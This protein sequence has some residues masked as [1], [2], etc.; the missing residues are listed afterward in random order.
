MEKNKNLHILWTNSDMLT[1]LHM[2]MMYATNAMLRGWWD[3]VTVIIWGGT[4]KLAAEN[5][6]IQAAIKTAQKAGV[7]FS[8]CIACANNL[9]VK[10][11]LEKLDIKVIAW[12]VPLTELLQDNAKLITI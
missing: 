2:V 5:K 11:E 9:G 3:A 4:A 12:G 7:K 8:A 6:E 1:S 10:E